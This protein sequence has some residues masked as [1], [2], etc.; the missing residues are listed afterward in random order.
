MSKDRRLAE[1]RQEALA[2]GKD[3]KFVNESDYYTYKHIGYS[4][5]EI[6]LD[7]VYIEEDSTEYEWTV[8]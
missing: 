6:T 2:V 4:P 7:M 1:L 8:N 3:P 5:E